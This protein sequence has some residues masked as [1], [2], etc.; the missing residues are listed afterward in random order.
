MSDHHLKELL[1]NFGLKVTDARIK[2]LS[3]LTNSDE[4]LSHSDIQERLDD[5]QIDKVTLYRTL[6]AFEEKGLAHKVATEDRNWRYA[7]HLEHT[8][9]GEPDEQHAHFVCHECERIYCFPVEGEGKL[10]SIQNK[11]GFVI[12]EQEIRLHGRCP[13]CKV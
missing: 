11:Q 10:V 7:V 12:E 8:A 13:D 4:A 3:V 1:R 2:V 6:N 9:N 5:T